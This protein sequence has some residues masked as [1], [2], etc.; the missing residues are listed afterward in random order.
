MVLD[1]K[2]LHPIRTINFFYRINSQNVYRCEFYLGAHPPKTRLQKYKK[3]E[4]QKKKSK[5]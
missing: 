5:K 2:I 1:S 3:K 4:S